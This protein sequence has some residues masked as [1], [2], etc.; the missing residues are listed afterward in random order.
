MKSARQEE[1]TR[2][3]DAQ[4]VIV[5][6]CIGSVGTGERVEKFELYDGRWIKR[7]AVLTSIPKEG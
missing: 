7:S 5:N 4:L 2:E 1:E 6:L 3:Q